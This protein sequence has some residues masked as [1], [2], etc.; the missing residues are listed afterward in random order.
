MK[1]TKYHLKRVVGPV[2][3]TFE[4][5]TTVLTQIEA[6]LNSRPLAPLTAEDDGVEALTPGHFLIGR[7]SESLPDPSFSFRSLNLLRR[8]NLCQAL[9]RHFWQ[10]WSSEYFCPPATIWKVASEAGKLGKRRYGHPQ[11]RQH[12]SIQMAHCTC[13]GDTSCKG[14]YCTRSHC[15]N[16]HWNLH[17]SC[18]ED[19]LTYVRQTL[20]LLSVKIAGLGWRLCLIANHDSLSL[21]IHNWRSSDYVTSP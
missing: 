8:W 1:S 20:T 16:S 10:C 9:V 4:E 11:G 13:I 15:A 2:K 6:C 21:C 3:L 18:R 17:P 12:G 14:W 19:C 5:L 7:P